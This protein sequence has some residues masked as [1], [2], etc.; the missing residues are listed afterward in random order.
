MQALGDS[1]I[2][3][4]CV[5]GQFRRAAELRCCR[6]ATPGHCPEAQ[7]CPCGGHAVI[8][9]DGIA[10][11]RDCGGNPMRPVKPTLNSEAAASATRRIALIRGRRVMLSTVLATEPEP[12]T[13]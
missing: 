5:A 7:W 2:G 8:E 13:Y 12:P 3:L 6:Y 1:K 11:S 9:N 4:R 10:G